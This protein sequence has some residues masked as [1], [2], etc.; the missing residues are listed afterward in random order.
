MAYGDLIQFS[1]NGIAAAQRWKKLELGTTAGKDEAWLRDALRDHADTIPVRAI[2]PAFGPL[3]SVCTE[4]PTRAG[5]VDNLFVS[6]NGRLTL[7]EC[8]LWRNQQAR[9]EVVAQ[10]LDYA[11]EIAT[12]SYSDLQ[13]NINFRTGKSGN[14]LFKLV[15]AEHPDIR[16]PDFIDDVETAL[17]Q[18]KFMLLI[19]GDGI[20]ADV[21]A[22]TELIDRQSTAAFT[23]G[24]VEV[25]MFQAPDHSILLQPRLLA[26]TVLIERTVVIVQG[27]PVGSSVVDS[28]PTSDDEPKEKNATALLAHQTMRAWWEPLLLAAKDKLNDPDQEPLAYFA[29][30]NVRAA[31]PW[32]GTWVLAYRSVSPPRLGVAFRG[33]SGAHIEALRAI[34]DYM[35]EV[36]ASL[37]EGTQYEPGQSL[38]IEVSSIDFPNDVARQKWLLENINSFVNELRSVLSSARKL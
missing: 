23:F 11:K 8:K 7:V 27:L 4:L 10:I 5:R 12:W 35:P 36:I 26:S 32:P 9:R 38:G 25:A 29:P 20:K 1:P 6:P 28:E 16:E 22:L 21:K 17:R 13:K 19:A 30:N 37:P 15:E 3:I 31:M 34:A 33:R 2:D 18:G 14:H 24:M